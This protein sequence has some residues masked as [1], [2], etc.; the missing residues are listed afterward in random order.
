M[1]PLVKLPE[2]IR[3]IAWLLEAFKR[4]GA[5]KTQRRETEEVFM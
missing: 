3:K 1:P 4:K 2:M 5:K